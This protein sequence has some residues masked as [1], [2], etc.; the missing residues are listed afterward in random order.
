MNALVRKEIRL[1]LP[2][3]TAALALAVAPVWFISVNDL[4]GWQH[5][6]A[7]IACYAFALGAMLLGLAPY[8]QEC[9]LGT[10]SL[11][12]AQPVCRRRI[13]RT[14]PRSSRSSGASGRVL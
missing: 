9:G 2:A 10:F 6:G 14:A 8:G 3:W 13:W 1:I 4:V 7:A 12:L 11:L 5:Q